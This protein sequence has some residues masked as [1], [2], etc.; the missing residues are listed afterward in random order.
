MA[1]FCALPTDVKAI[2]S[3]GCNPAIMPPVWSVAG[4]LRE[5]VIH[6]ILARSSAGEADF[7]TPDGGGYASATVPPTERQGAALNY[8]VPKNYF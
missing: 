3:R 4:T 7:H 8:K 2:L 6:L 5:R 1:I